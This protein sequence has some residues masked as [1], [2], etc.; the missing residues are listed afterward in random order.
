MKKEQANRSAC[1][2]L[3]LVVF[4]DRSGGAIRHRIINGGF[5]G[6]RASSGLGLP[7]ISE[8]ED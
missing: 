7:V 6:D 8:L 5:V 4:D 1:S 2:F 3:K